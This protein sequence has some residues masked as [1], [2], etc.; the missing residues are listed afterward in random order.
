MLRLERDADGHMRAVPDT[1][2]YHEATGAPDAG[3]SAESDVTS[4]AD[5]TGRPWRIW[6][7]TDPEPGAAPTFDSLD[8]LARALWF[9]E[10]RADDHAACRGAWARLCAWIVSDYPGCHAKRTPGATG[11][12]LVQHT[13][14]WGKDQRRPYV[15]PTLP[16][17]LARLFAA[18]AP[19]HRMELLSLPDATLRRYTQYDARVAH[20]AYLRHLP[21]LLGE[22]TS[23]LLHDDDPTYIPYRAGK[24]RVAVTVPQG[25]AHI[26]LAHRAVTTPL[27]ATWDYPATPGE[28]WETWLDA[29]EVQLLLTNDVGPWPVAIR[30]RI[31]FADGKTPGADPLREHAARL[32]AYLERLDRAQATS[33]AMTPAQAR[34]L[35]ALRHAARAVA[36]HPIGLWHK[37]SNQRPRH[38]AS[39][40]ELTP[41]DAEATIVP[42]D[43]GDGYIVTTSAA[44]SGYQAHWRR[45]EWSTTIYA[46]ERVNAARRALTAPRARVL[47]IRGDAVH[48]ADYAPAWPDTGKVGAYRLKADVRSWG[49]RRAP[50]TATELLALAQEE[51]EESH[52]LTR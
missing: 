13:L 47:G 45:V 38:V 17:D 16:A 46:R 33:A 43:T 21:V 31:L 2:T 29:S 18:T 50:Q 42:A 24:Y 30:E 37:S 5:A 14:P 52:G 41:A 39:L 8:Y 36:L 51:E 48:F 25:W 19:Q 10:A 34:T 15:Y 22:D 23:S 3:A 1:R 44:L 6:R 4:D 26:G 40:D 28:E 12:S 11:L 9:G 27:G 20:A 35:A 32:T 7:A 49:P